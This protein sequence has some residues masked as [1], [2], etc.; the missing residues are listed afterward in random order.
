MSKQRKSSKETMSNLFNRYVWLV[1]LIYR[2]RRITYEEVSNAWCNSSLNYSGDG[3]PLRT[4]H[5]HRAA[6]AAMFDIDIECDKRNG[7]VYYIENSED[8]ARGGVRQWL[9]NTFAV[10]NLINESHKLKSRILFEQIPSGQHYLTPI[11]E[12]MRDGLA[13]EITYESFWRSEV[14]TFPIEPYCVKVF[15][16]RWYV[17]GRSPLK[18]ELRIYALDRIVDLFTTDQKFTLP[19][20]FSGAEYFQHAFG[21]IPEDGWHDV[22]YVE[23]K[24]YGKQ[25]NYIRTLPLHHSQEEVETNEEFTIFR[26]LLCPTYDFRQ[27]VLSHG[28]RVEVL[29]PVSFRTE[30]AEAVRAQTRRYEK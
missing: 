26:Y 8:V 6:V 19:K 23:L 2:R 24:V 17:V 15:K 16:Q 29:S 25:A 5:N 13:V 7:F 14:H 21:I 3:L 27:E 22:E 4:F 12:A 10:N 9:V 30:V 20:D 1:D 28:D 18:N 11:I